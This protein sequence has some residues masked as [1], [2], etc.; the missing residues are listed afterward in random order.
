MLEALKYCT[1][2]PHMCRVNR[3][4]GETGQ[5][6]CTDKIKISLVSLHHFEEPCISGTHGSGTVFF[7]HCN[8][9]CLYCQ[10]YQISQKGKGYFVS[11]ED[12][13]NIF[14]DLQQKGAHNINLVTPTS[15]AYHII[16]AIKIAKSRGL[17]LPIIYNTNAYERVETLQQLN[18]LI[19]VYLPDL[20]YYSDEMS[21]K[22]SQVDNYFSFAAKAILEMVQQVGFPQVDDQGLIQKGVI[23]RHLILPGHL[24]NSKHIL[25]WM[26]EN[27]EGKAFVSI[28]AQYFPTYK[29]KN[30]ASINRKLTKREYKEIETFLYTLQLQNGYLQELGDHEEEYVPHF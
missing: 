26:K 21:Q 18:G 19:D 6:H 14:L 27:V 3:L 15:Y 10:N 20:K 7:S 13:A 12:L 8:L 23:I 30:D 16:E 4:E 24:Q 11:I 22:Y 9:H 28:M 25:K 1:I 29:S 2:C 5:C 17:H